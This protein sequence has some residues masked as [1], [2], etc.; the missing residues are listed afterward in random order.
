MNK[1]NKK[2]LNMI[3]AAGGVAAL[4][5]L[6]KKNPEL[7]D[8]INGIVD[9]GCLNLNEITSFVDNISNKNNK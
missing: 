4:T 7:I 1:L 2:D 5:I 9:K 6:L 3:A 8:K